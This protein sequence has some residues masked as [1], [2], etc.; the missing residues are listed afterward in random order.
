MYGLALGGG[1]SRG[2]YEI[3][4]LKALQELNIE[5]G[6]IT[7]TSIG[8]INAAAYLMNDFTLMEEI[9][10]SLNRDSLIKFESQLVPEVIRQRGL[11]FEI[12]LSLLHEILDEETI[13]NHPTDLGIVT[14]NLTARKPV[15]LFK[16]EIPQGKL[17][18]YVAASANHPSFQ[19]LLI[20]GDA[21]IDGAV[22]DNIPVRPLYDRGY[23]E[24][25]AVNLHTFGDRRNL[26]G[27]YQLIEIES[28]NPLGSILF[29]DPET[30]RNNMTYG[31]LDTLRAFKKLYGATYYFEHLDDFA[32]LSS[33][34]AE[35][36]KTLKETIHPFFLN[37]TLEKYQKLLFTDYSLAQAALEITAEALEISPLK[38][39][40]HQGELLDAIF[41]KIQE[42]VQGEDK[43]PWK[44]R[45][46]FRELDPPAITA[47]AVTS[48]KLA[49]ANLF[50]KMIQNRILGGS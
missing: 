19:R 16:E 38:V 45:A 22:F 40:R 42:M 43:I 14:Y 17:I 33:L 41:S 23:T 3:G 21:Y 35:E 13:R 49:I 8:A 12:L 32:L 6:A 2:S 18:D 36:V 28:D 47:L 24:I 46:V 4:V 10:M 30:I 20:D 48:P 5:I 39:Y 29:P 31:Y 11:D 25:I 34:N 15:V 1:G 26:S 44:E 27:P 37:K 50:I 7:G 9:W